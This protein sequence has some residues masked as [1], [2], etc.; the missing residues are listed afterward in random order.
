M[1]I[2]SV[3][4]CWIFFLPSQR[5]IIDDLSCL[6]LLHHDCAKVLFWVVIISFSAN[7]TLYIYTLT[8][9]MDDANWAVIISWLLSASI[10]DVILMALKNEQY[11]NIIY[12][13]IALLFTIV[14]IFV[15]KWESISSGTDEN[16]MAVS[17]ENRFLRMI[18]PLK[19]LK[20]MFSSPLL[21]NTIQ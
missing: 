13:V 12:T 14:G 17:A 7:I 15:Y 3:F 19:E 21:A 4:L 8:A 18:F 16:E 10:S 5:H 20:E 6:L 11:I 2:C 1:C 9:K